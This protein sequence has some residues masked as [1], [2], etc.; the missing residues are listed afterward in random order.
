MSSLMRWIAAALLSFGLVLPAKAIAQASWQGVVSY[1]VDGDTLYVR[2]TGGGK[3]RSVRLLGIDAPEICQAGGVRAREVLNAHV[4][5]R[6]VT[7][8]TQGKDS[9]GRHLS[10]VQLDNYDL[11]HWM[12]SQGHAWSYRYRNQLGLY[13]PVQQQA[14]LARHG[15]FADAKAETPGAFRRRNG[16]CRLPP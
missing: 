12:V 10:T 7:V 15:L 1:V 16:S 11:G 8:F 9:Y 6:E 5:T 3:P 2:P 4:L 13:D 14:R